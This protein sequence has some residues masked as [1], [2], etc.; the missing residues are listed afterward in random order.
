M[1]NFTTDAILPQY[2][3][4]TKI[5]VDEK[6]YSGTITFPGGIS[7][8]DDAGKFEEIYSDL[9]EDYSKDEYDSFISYNA[10]KSTDDDF[11]SINMYA[12]PETGKI[13]EYTYS[14]G[15]EIK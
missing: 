7:V 3:Y 5:A 2:G 6:Y 13:T 10:Y 9:G 12:D 15:K 14:S 8:G 4:I 11:I 1:E